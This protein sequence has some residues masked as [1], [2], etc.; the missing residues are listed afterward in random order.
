[1]FF[2]E[3]YDKSYYPRIWI[4]YTILWLDKDEEGRPRHINKDR[5]TIPIVN[6]PLTSSEQNDLTKL[7]WYLI[8]WII[9]IALQVVTILITPVWVILDAVF[10]VFWF[11]VI[12]GTFLYQSRNMAMGKLANC[13]FELELCE[14]FRNI[15][16]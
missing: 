1:M 13:G 5:L 3:L 14:I 2:Y 9:L 15:G 6:I 8:L 12:I 7:I 4:P 16:R 11:W 10:L